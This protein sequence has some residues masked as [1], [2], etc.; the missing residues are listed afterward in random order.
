M[1]RSFNVPTM[2]AS[3]LGDGDGDGVGSSVN[4]CLCW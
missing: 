3:V 4:T 2:P 1:S